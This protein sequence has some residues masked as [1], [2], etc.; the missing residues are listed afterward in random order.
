MSGITSPHP[1][2]LKEGIRLIKMKLLLGENES[3]KEETELKTRLHQTL[4]FLNCGF[5]QII[6]FA[7]YGCSNLHSRLYSEIM[8]SRLIATLLNLFSWV[9]KIKHN[10]DGAIYQWVEEVI[11]VDVV[12]EEWACFRPIRSRPRT[13][14]EN[15]MRNRG[16]AHV[17]R[18]FTRG[19]WNHHFFQ[20]KELIN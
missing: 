1:A 18:P 15:S 20:P 4:N 2:I 16:A 6:C 8:W 7:L 17:A 3:E 10:I 12:D 19:C 9:L 13:F 11:L 14:E 5:R